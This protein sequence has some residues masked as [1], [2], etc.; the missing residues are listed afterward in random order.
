MVTIFHV[1]VP[2]ARLGLSHICPRV[3][4][5]AANMHKFFFAPKSSA[6]L[7]VRRDRQLPH[8]PAPAV[9]DSLET[10]NFTDRFIWTG[11]RDRTAYCAIEA[12]AAFREALGGEAAV[13][14]YNAALALFAKRHLESAWGVPPMAPDAMMSSLSIVQLPTSNAT[15]CGIVRGA[16]ISEY[17]LMVSGWTAL[18]GIE[19]YLRISGQVY[20]EESDIVRLGDA[21]IAILARLG[22]PTRLLPPL[23][24]GQADM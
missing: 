17:G 8:V 22:E 10:Q 18:P 1:F 6:L 12:A 9:V 20:L 2:R 15:V 3:T 14:A 4:H 16:L 7:Y 5:I 23:R 21:V 13:Q 19:C 11:T 24:V